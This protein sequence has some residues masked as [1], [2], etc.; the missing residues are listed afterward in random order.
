MRS[1]P[2]SHQMQYRTVDGWSLVYEGPVF[3][4]TNAAD[5]RSA[6]LLGEGPLVG[7][8]RKCALDSR[9]EGTAAAAS[10]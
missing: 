6:G 4:W 9:H 5:E 2:E 7:A 10:R 3:L 1:M 8:H